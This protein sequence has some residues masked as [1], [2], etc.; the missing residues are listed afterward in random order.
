MLPRRDL[1]KRHRS[2]AA[3]QLLDAQALSRQLTAIDP[4]WRRQKRLGGPLH[5]DAVAL[6]RDDAGLREQPEQRV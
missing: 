6:F 4:H 3:A 2:R 1:S 5:R